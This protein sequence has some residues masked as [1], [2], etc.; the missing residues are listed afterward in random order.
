MEMST[1]RLAALLLLLLLLY[2][3][4]AVHHCRPQWIQI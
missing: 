3:A 4:H 2:S 1:L